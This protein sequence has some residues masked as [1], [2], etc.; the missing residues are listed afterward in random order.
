MKLNAELADR[1]SLV[2]I[3]DG[4]RIVAQIDDR[5]YE[6]EVHESGADSYLIISHGRVFECRVEGRPESG[7]TIDV[8]VGTSQFA[9]TLTDPRRLSSLAAASGQGDDQARIVAA[10]PGKVVRILVE[11]GQQVAAGAGLIVVEAMK[12]Q[13]EM[14]SPK[15]GTVVAL[16][17][18]TGATVNRGDVLMVVE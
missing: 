2:T 17:T 6:L 9:V 16:N 11:M 4:A 5:Q 8:V 15:S 1:K 13:N 3:Q 10:M 12:M 14:K 18:Q 7:K